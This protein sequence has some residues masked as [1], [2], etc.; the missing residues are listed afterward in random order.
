[1]KI[2][3][4]LGSTKGKSIDAKII[5]NGNPGV[6]GTE[7]C[8]LQLA[9]YLKKNNHSVLLIAMRD[10][11]LEEGLSFEKVDSEAT[12]FS[13]AE[14]NNVDVIITRVSESLDFR[15]AI[16]NSKIKVVIWSHNFLRPI[17]CDL[18]SSCSNI[19]AN[20]FVGKQMY[21][22]YIDDDIIKKSTYIYNMYN[23]NIQNLTRENDSSSVVYMGALK[24]EKGF[25]EVAK[26]WPKIK[27]KVP[28]AKLLVMG[29]GNLYGSSS[30]GKFN[31]AE[32]SYEEKFMKY[33]TD[34]N[35]N[36]DSSVK[37]LG[38]VGSG[39]YEIFRK[40]SV[41]VV[42]PTG[43]SETFGMGIVEMAEAGLPVATIKYGGYIDTIIHNKTGL[44][45]ITQYGICKNIIF[46]LKHNKINCELGINAKKLA[47]RYSEDVVG[48][49]W[50]DLL[51][52]VVDGKCSLH[53][54]GH[55][56]PFFT[57]MKCFRIFNRFIRF[58]CGLRLIPSL[59]SIEYK[60]KFI[61]ERIS[62]K[63]FL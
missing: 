1:M 8:M 31:L 49:Q 12:I 22:R 39:K 21:D 28:N 36:L 17:S 52:S 47:K 4:F 55:S 40:C 61:L 60:F 18:I 9:H 2:C 13:V 63:Y 62:Q 33:L 51:S 35:G 54:L 45:A 30:L 10:Y 16:M 34:S 32:K 42:N 26:M 6:G 15:L 29:S 53:Y 25:L 11:L 59:I 46:L 24:P 5:E 48:T 27:S 14:I 7:F 50:I 38:V 37:F 23:D 57:Q 3:I 43:K 58:S 41:G 56:S 20:V 19:K 44:L